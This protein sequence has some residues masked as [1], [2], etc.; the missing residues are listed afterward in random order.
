MFAFYLKKVIGM[1][2][3]PIPLTIC[4]LMLG[5]LLL[6]R[7]PAYGKSLIAA[8]ALFLG[9]T[10]W[11]PIADHLLKPF[12]NDYPSFDLQQPVAAVVVLGG[13]HSSSDNRPPASQL[14]GTSLHRLQEGLRILQSNP[15]A[16]LFVSGFEGTDTRS[17]AEVSREV[18]IALGV[19]PERIKTFAKARDTQEEAELMAPYLGEKPFAL[20]SEASHLP[21]AITFFE[22]QGLKPIAAPAVWQVGDNSNWKVDASAQ[23]KSER[24]FYEAL[25]RA[26]HYLKSRF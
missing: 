16:W 11:H 13:C 20:V 18:A 9:L 6:R 23:R 15:A 8:S 5:L 26:W 14:C 19:A 3:M 24:A 4:G 21:R 7:Y 22:Q 10:S 12:E 17:H 25:G 2:L 1:M